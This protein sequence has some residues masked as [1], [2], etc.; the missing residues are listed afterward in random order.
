MKFRIYS[1][2]PS[3]L[4]LVGCVFGAQAAFFE[5]LFKITSVKGDVMIMRPDHDVPEKALEAHVYPYGSRILLPSWNSKSKKVE[6]EVGFSLSRD[7]RFRLSGNADLQVGTEPNDA[8]DKKV[9]TLKSGKLKT[10]I[11]ISTV[12][13]GGAEDEAVEAGIQALSIVTP[14]A[15]CRRLTDRNEITVSQSGNTYAMN[16]VTESG[17]MDIEGAQ[18]KITAMRRNANME[19][20]GEEDYTR[21]QNISSEFTVELEK[22]VDAVEKVVFRPRSIAKIWRSYAE[23]GGKQAV[24][25]MIAFPDGSIKSYAYLQ[26]EKVVTD[27]TFEEEEKVVVEG[28]L[29]VPSRDDEVVGGMFPAAVGTEVPVGDADVVQPVADDLGGFN[30][31]D[32]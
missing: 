2:V 17:T 25:V 22:G 30:F 31:D 28:E 23:I 21:I 6:P 8:S 27:S 15:V 29:V 5:P 32:W 18:F 4:V 9:F 13:T 20:Y 3:L 10:F 11:S 16:V 19:I 7:H 14:L 26:G 1:A 24:S 12:K